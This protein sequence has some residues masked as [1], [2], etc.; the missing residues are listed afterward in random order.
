MRRRG[1]GLAA[2]GLGLLVPLIEIVPLGIP[3]AFAGEVLDFA[4][5]A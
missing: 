5:L 3:L 4:W 1:T 2:P